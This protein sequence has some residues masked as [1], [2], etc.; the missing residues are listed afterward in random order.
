MSLT[1]T[2]CWVCEDRQ[3]KHLGDTCS[4]HE[5]MFERCVKCKKIKH[6]SE[7][8]EIKGWYFSECIEECDKEA[9]IICPNAKRVKYC[10]SK[11]IVID[12]VYK[13]IKL[14]KLNKG[15]LLNFL[16]NA[17]EATE[18][19]SDDNIS[20]TT[21][22]TLIKVLVMQIESGEYDSDK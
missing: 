21:F 12:G 4:E 5:V 13:K 3:R 7:L 17:L 19:D 18:D 11:Y 6:K 9:K 15:K 22:N 8:N 1:M 14:K 10:T 16:K 2:E 20:N